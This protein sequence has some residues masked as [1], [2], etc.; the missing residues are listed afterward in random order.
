M[1]I[2]GAQMTP[3]RAALLADDFVAAHAVS[4]LNVAGPRA[5]RNSE[6]QEFAYRTVTELLRLQREATQSGA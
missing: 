6:A 4:V 1:V 3:A 5:S 2:D